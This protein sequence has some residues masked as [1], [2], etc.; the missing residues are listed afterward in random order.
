M[1][2]PVWQIT[3]WDRMRGRGTIACTGMGEIEFD[4]SVA[5]VDDFD[6]GEGVHVELASHDDSFRVTKIWPDD[7]HVPYSSTN[8]DAPASIPRSQRASRR[9][10]PSTR[11][12]STIASSIS[13]AI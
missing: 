3:S 13:T 10:W 11:S 4:G 6:V 9:C 1:S 2:L 8:P 5:L 7:P 12:I